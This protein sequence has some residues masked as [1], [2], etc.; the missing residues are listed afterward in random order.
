MVPLYAAQYPTSA[1]R[2]SSGS[3]DCTCGDIA[4]LTL[5]ML[6]TALIRKFSTYSVS[7]NASPADGAGA[8]TC[9][10]GGRQAVSGHYTLAR[11]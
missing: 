5:L 1:L 2:T 3:I 7:S 8:P 10:L 6:W 11:S 4:E 9:R